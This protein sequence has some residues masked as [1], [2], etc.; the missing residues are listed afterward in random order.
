MSVFTTFFKRLPLESTPQFHMFSMTH[1][2]TL[3][4]SIAIIYTV[5]KY[6]G[7]L[8]EW[9]YEKILRYTLGIMMIYTNVNLW[10]YSYYLGQEWYHYLPIATCGYATFFGGLTL[11]TK[12]KVLFKLTFFWGFGAVLSLLGPTMLEGPLKY[13]YYQFFFRHIGIIVIPFYMMNVYDYKIVRE[14]WKLFFYVTISLTFGSTIINLIVNKPDELNMFYTMQPVITGTPL[15]TLYEVSRWV[16][17]AFW[18]PFAALLGYLYGLPFYQ[19]KEP[20][21]K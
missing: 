15:N 18:I 4:V 12:N 5:Y 21:L 14:D 20:L 3:I 17:V 8:K 16:Y 2:I 1:F 13:H 11:L 6:S 9:K 7:K 10:Q 19:K